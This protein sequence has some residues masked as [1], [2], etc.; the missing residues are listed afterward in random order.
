MPK[1]TFDCECGVQFT[2]T[3]KMGEHPFHVCPG[4]GGEAPRVFEGFSHA[5]AQGATPTNTG[6]AKLDYP[7]ADQ[8]VGSNADARWAEITEREK[9]KKQVRAM[10]KTHALSRKTG[11][12]FIEYTAGGKPL[13]EQRKQLVKAVNEVYKKVGPSSQ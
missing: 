4:C 9:V 1:F 10:G 11:K 3:L 6:V 12:D 8:A 2:R 5:F 7:T 13:V